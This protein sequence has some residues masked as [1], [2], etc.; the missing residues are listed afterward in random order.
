MSSSIFLFFVYFMCFQGT[1]QAD[2]NTNATSK[3][4]KMFKVSIRNNNWIDGCGQM[5]LQLTH[6]K[7]R[8]CHHI[9]PVNWFAE[10]INWLVSIWWQ[11]Y[12]GYINPF[13]HSV[14]FH[15][16]TSHLICK[17]NQ[18]TG[19]FMKCNAGLKW[20]NLIFLFLNLRNHS[21]GIILG[22]AS[23]LFYTK[24]LGNPAINLIS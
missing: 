2:K 24:Y 17:A 23:Q 1:G 11:L 6:F 13:K 9:E 5:S 19:F 7:R 12:P 20:V 22:K 15:I 10:Q 18:M 21:T 4:S 14:P 3:L 8:S 16:E